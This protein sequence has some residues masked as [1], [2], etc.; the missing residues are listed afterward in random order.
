MRFLV[1]GGTGFIGSRVADGLIRRGH[2]VTVFH[3]GTTK[4][5]ARAD[6]IVG[7]RHRLREH[8]AALRASR[9]DA[10]VDMAL[11]SGR[12][13]REVTEIMLGYTGRIV[14]ASSMDVYRAVAVTHRL[15]EGPAEPL[16]LREET[17][18]LRTKFQT[19]PAEQL[20][21]LGQVF[22]WLDDEYDKIPVEREILRHEG[23]SGT[24]LRLPMVYGPGDPLHR[25]HPIVKRIL[26]GR[27]AI[28]F[29]EA[30]APWRATKGYVDDVAA[31][32]VLAAV[33][34]AAAGRIYNVGEA[35]TLT[36]LEWARQVAHAMEWDGELF[37]LPD[38]NLPE[39]LRAPGDASQA[40]VAD[41]SRIRNELGFRES[42]D[43]RE[44]VRRTVEWERR[45]PPAGFS[46]HQ[47][48]YDAEDR[49]L[50]TGRG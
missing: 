44:A 32:I 30:M 10:V 11:S 45:N 28:L 9:P 12:Q 16:P 8:A 20:R 25:F 5:P 40:W 31:A 33:E 1:I 22:G 24:V 48:D 34:G 29:S 15:E 41:T 14:A 43:R 18:A 38:A 27:R 19:Y 2:S 37:L 42:V 35:E 17:S 46:P 50:D 13:A 26:D 6:E 3:R 36:E 4:R 47:F 21:A 49:A 7:D 39:H 23:L